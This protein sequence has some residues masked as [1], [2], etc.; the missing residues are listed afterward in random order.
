MYKRQPNE[1][2]HAYIYR[3]CSLKDTI[4]TWSNVRDII[5]AELG[6]QRSESTYRKVYQAFA[7]M[8]AANEDKFIQDKSREEE[9]T[10]LKRELEKERVKLKTEKQE[11]NKWLREEA[12]E[13]MIYERVADAI[14]TLDPITPPEYIPHISSNRKAGILCFGDEHYGTEFCVRGLDG[15]VINM[16][17]PEIFEHRM[18]KLLCDTIELVHLYGFDVIRVYS[19]GDFIDG[20]LRIGQLMTLRYGV[21]ES[22]IRY[23]EFMAQWLNKLT[24]YVR[25]EYQTVYGNHPELRM[26]GAQKGSF[27]DDNMGEVVCKFIETRLESNPNFTMTQCVGGIIRDRIYGY[28][29]VG[30]HGET[31]SLEQTLKNYQAMYQTSIDILIGAHIHHSASESI[32]ICK[33]VVRIPSIMGTDPYSIS[34]EKA[35]SPGATF[36]VIEDEVGKSAEH[37]IK[38]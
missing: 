10:R 11:Y 21:V 16:Y 23:A 30:I 6:Y 37:H 20:I 32:G 8:L 3:I 14:K 26:L 17:S 9:L 2:E 36:L 33:D 5:N 12:R 18:G 19:M 31:K 38:F 29:I 15:Q 27:K 25:V 4:G 22:T 7:T 28:N 34:L 35:S 13:E 24:E 1:N